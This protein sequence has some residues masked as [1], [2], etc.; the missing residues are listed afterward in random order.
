[1]A[2]DRH[3]KGFD[4]LKFVLEKN[5][6]KAFIVC[7]KNSKIKKYCENKKNIYYIDS[8]NNVEKYFIIYLLTSWSYFKF[9]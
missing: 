4:R 6:D 1:M 2:R 9:L 7:T 5:K 8:C 3:Y